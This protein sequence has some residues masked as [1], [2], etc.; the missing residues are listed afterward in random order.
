MTPYALNF[1]VKT[2]DDYMQERVIVYYSTEQH[3]KIKMLYAIHIDDSEI[4]NS[5]QGTGWRGMVYRLYMKY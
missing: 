1:K 4:I 5:R 2:M 3:H